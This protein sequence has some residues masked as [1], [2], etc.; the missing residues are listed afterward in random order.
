MQEVFYVITV[1]IWLRERMVP[2]GSSRARILEYKKRI[3]LVY[4]G[5]TIAAGTVSR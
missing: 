4:H 3:D 2:V 5:D 1:S